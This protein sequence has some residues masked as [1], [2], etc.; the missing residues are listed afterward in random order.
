MKCPKCNEDSVLPHKD[1]SKLGGA[2]GGAAGAA[3]GG[4]GL[5]EGAAAGA[6][7]DTAILLVIGTALGAAGGAVAGMLGGW[8]LGSRLGESRRCAVR[9]LHV[10]FVRIHVV[11]GLKLARSA[12]SQGG[13]GEASDCLS[14]R[15][16]FRA[17][18]VPTTERS[19]LVERVPSG[20][21]RRLW[22]QHRGRRRSQSLSQPGDQRE[23]RV[24]RPDAECTPRTGEVCMA[25]GVDRVW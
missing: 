9:W 25:R 24:S 15:L 1:G 17:S 7:A 4:F 2:I 14:L 16:F 18:W 20:L 19:D 21:L 6:L 10:P 12:R 5:L 11:V 3:A 22:R 23:R 13:E 8:L